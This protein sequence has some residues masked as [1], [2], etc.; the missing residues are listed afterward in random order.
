MPNMAVYEG[1]MV[2]R[3]KDDRFTPELCDTIDALLKP[4]NTDAPLV[5]WNSIKGSLLDHKIAYKQKNVSP[6]LLMFHSENRDGLGVNGFQVHELGEKIMKTGGAWREIGE[7][8]AFEIHTANKAA[9]EKLSLFNMELHQGSERKVGDKT[10]GYMLPK[11]Y[12]KERFVAVSSCH[13]VTFCRAA[14]ALLA[15]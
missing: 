13:T 4:S 8:V 3:A 2:S 9:A 12:G 7:S 1:G 5:K 11:V 6:E 15:L 10:E 14:T